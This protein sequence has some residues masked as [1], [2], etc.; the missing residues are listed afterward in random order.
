MRLIMRF[1]DKKLNT[2]ENFT[3]SI[4]VE[5]MKHLIPSINKKY[6]D[7]NI[8]PENEL[9][10]L[11]LFDFVML[12]YFIKIFKLEENSNSKIMENI[13][14]FINSLFYFGK[15]LFTCNNTYL[16]LYLN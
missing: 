2:K 5:N 16:F 13:S 6:K 8:S 3:Y 15:S 11:K 1:I 7:L 9:E 10:N 14:N 12:I 4:N